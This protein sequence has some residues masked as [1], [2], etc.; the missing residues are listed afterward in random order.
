[1]PGGPLIVGEGS[2]IDS[3]IQHPIPI[4]APSDKIRV[5]PRGV[6][7]TKKEMRKM[8]K[9]RRAA[10]LQDKRDRIK[11]G[12]LPPEAPKGELGPV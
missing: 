5:E 12:L 8:R 4:P 7:L 2:P 3:Y 1:M 9:Q 6:M 11:M 10:E